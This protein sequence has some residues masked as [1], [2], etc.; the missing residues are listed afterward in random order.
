MSTCNRVE[1]YAGVEDAQRAAGAIKDFLAEFHNI[2]RASLDNA[3]YI[4][5]DIKAV[6]HMFRVASSLDS[7]VVGEP[8]ILGQ[9]KAAFDLALSKKT[10][11]LLLNKLIKKSI[12]WPI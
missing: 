3:L 8:Q 5:D 9:L 6:R 4:Y 11:G 2:K 10:T 1:L 12:Y 7:M